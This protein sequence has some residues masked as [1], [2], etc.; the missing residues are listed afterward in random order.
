[1]KCVVR[2]INSKTND[3]KLAKYGGSRSKKMAELGDLTSP[4]YK[5]LYN[6]CAGLVII[7]L[8]KPFIIRNFRKI[9]F[10][11]TFHWSRAHHVT[12]I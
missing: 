8:I 10:S 9:T 7:L 6:A 5:G 3:G 1:M 2:A 11:H 4:L 12:C